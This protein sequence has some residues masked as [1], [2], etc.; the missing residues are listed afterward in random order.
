MVTKEKIRKLKQ[1]S[2]LFYDA[3]CMAKNVWEPNYRAGHVFHCAYKGAFSIEPLIN[4]YTLIFH[5]KILNLAV[6]PLIYK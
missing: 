6:K 3:H 1:Y 4:S 2:T 5:I